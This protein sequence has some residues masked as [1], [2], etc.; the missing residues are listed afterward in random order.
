LYAIRAHVDPFQVAKS[1]TCGPL[2]PRDLENFSAFEQIFDECFGWFYRHI[3]IFECYGKFDY[4][5][6][7][8][9]IPSPTYMCHPGT[10]WGHMGEMPREGYWNNNERDPLRGILL[11][12]LRSGK[13]EAWEL[14][15]IMARHILDIDISHYPRWGMYTH[16][17]GHCYLGINICG[18]PDHSWFLGL[19][20]WVGVS[21]D[22]L[23][24]EWILKCGE[25]LLKEKKDF[26]S[27]DCRNAAMQVHI[28][29][30][31]YLHTGDKRYLESAKKV[32]DIFIKLQKSDGSWPGRF[33][34]PD[35]PP[36]PSFT[37]HAIMALADYFDATKDERILPILKKAL[38][39]ALPGNG[40]DLKDVSEAGLILYGVAVVA[41]NTNDP[42]YGEIIQNIFNILN[43]KQNRSSDSICRGDWYPIYEVY[44]VQNARDD[45]RPP[46]FC[47]QSRP[48]IPATVLAYAPRALWIL[49]KQ[50]GL[51]LPQNSK[52][53]NLH[54]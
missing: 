29:T 3:R 34:E 28:M 51:K 16:T 25:E 52:K 30:Q 19:L 21:G 27:T 50:K 17:Y 8:Y 43:I 13:Q 24:W 53:V 1:Q 31:F 45:D 41:E 18:N 4:G 23:A 39:W 5:D 11:Y 15:K 37:E 2:W 32:I 26:T 36:H 38:K 49:A 47:G 9:F 42:V 12:Y 54:Q 22:F 40:K 48:L 20:E 35:G 33:S 6:F 10:K 46:Q 7:R 44:N 14:C